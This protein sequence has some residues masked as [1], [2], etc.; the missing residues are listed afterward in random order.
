MQSLEYA[1]VL[2]LLFQGSHIA[3]HSCGTTLHFRQ[4]CTGFQ[5]LHTPARAWDPRDCYSSPLLGV[6]ASLVQIHVDTE[7]Q[8]QVKVL[9]TAA[10]V[11]RCYW[12]IISN[13]LES[14]HG[15]GLCGE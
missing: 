9:K 13:F 12:E 5:V 6:R 10:H 3:L 1:V 11:L 14:D 2:F 4:Q 8:S 7:K 15:I